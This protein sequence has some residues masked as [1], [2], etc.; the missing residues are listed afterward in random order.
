MEQGLQQAAATMPLG[1][2]HAAGCRVKLY[3]LY[4][5][6]TSDV[7]ETNNTRCDLPVVTLGAL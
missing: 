2:G 3:V 1:N 7:L 5:K 6:H 4:S